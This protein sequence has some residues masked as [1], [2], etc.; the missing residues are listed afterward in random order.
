[1]AYTMDQLKAYYKNANGGT[2]PTAGQT[3]QLQIIYNQNLSG[4]YNDDQAFQAVVDLASDSTT[5]VS[6]GTYEFF[7]GFAPSKA[8]LAAL[9]AAYVGTGT[10]ANMNAENRF[11]A[12]SISLALQNPT[13][14]ANF[15]SVYG[16]GTVQEAA[17][18]AYLTII[19]NVAAQANNIN[20]DNAVAFLTSANSI[21]YYTALV[22]STNPGISAADLE[23]GVRAA[24]VGEI[25]FQATSYN[26]G[27][28]IGSYAGASNNL[29][30][31]LAFDGVLTADNAAGIDLFASYGGTGTP[32]SSLVLTTGSDVIV[33]TGNNDTI[34]ATISPVNGA[35]DSTSTFSALDTV[36]GGAGTDTLVLNDTTGTGD[37]T[38]VK[39]TVSNVETVKLQSTGSS[40]VDT[41][42]WNGVTSLSTSTSGGVT[43]TAGSSTSISAVDDKQAA[44]TITINGG[45]NVSVTTT[46]AGTGNIAIGQTTAATG[47]VTVKATETAATTQGTIQVQGGTTVSITQAATNAVNTTATLGAV[48]VTGT[49]GTTNVSVTQ[50]AAATAAAAV[51]GVVGGAVTINDVNAASTTKAGTIATVTIANS[52]NVAIGDNS[53]TALN[54]SGIVGTVGIT[55]NATAISSGV[56]ATT[57]AL[58]LGKGTTGTITANQYKTI[59]A[60]VTGANTVAGIAASAATAL[61]V[62][63]SDVLTLTSAAGLTA[64]TSVAVTGSA[65]LT[66]NL[67]ALGTV[68]KV[69]TSG[70]TGTSTLTIDATKVAFTGGAGS[71]LITLTGA[72]A[73]G[74]KID[75]GAG[76]DRL[77]GATAVAASTT[78]VIDGGT[79]TDAVASTLINAG[80]GALFK[81]FE[82][83]GLANT[84]GTLDASL[85]TG[86]TLTGLELLATGGTY[87]GVLASQSLSV[88]TNVGAGTTTLTFANVGGSADAYTINFAGI[89]GATAGAAVTYDAGT[90]AIA[91]I[92]NVTINSGSASGFSANNIDLTDAAARSL[93]ITGSQ[94]LDVSFVTAFGTAGANGLATIDASAATGAI[95][96][97]T[98]NAGIATGGLTV[99]TGSANDS[100][101][102]A[103]AA[104]ISTGAGNDTIVAGGVSTINAGVG[105]DTVTLAGATG[106]TVDLGAGNDTVTTSAGGSTITLGGGNDAINV[107]A[108]VA[109]STTAPTL[110]TITDAFGSGDSL[111]FANQGTEVFTSAAANVSAATSLV[112]AL[113]IAI[114]AAGDTNGQ[115]VWFQ[116]GGNTYVVEH[117]GASTNF[118]VTDIVVKLAGSVDLST[119][120]YTAGTNTLAL[121]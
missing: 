11:I 100:V 7:L 55:A 32:G 76:N 17:K 43:A 110:T 114:T 5:A 34:T 119:A 19:G 85:L 8:G 18:L 105:N 112:N 88:A 104:T 63:G 67:S 68:S 10:Q 93:T 115:I 102:L 59:N 92:E 107:A 69:D 62:S 31:D 53:L 12:Q 20:V 6:V 46:S 24:V 49:A 42:S 50:T 61:N 89:G 118:D 56:A 41:S 65:G 57:L 111:V 54:L 44:G 87:T 40:T 121:A 22:K 30:K 74:G 91:N 94:A 25:L 117:L 75:L 58:G 37:F 81:N 36:D 90:V 70:T 72:L 21:T 97:N 64:L 71:D 1:M 106:S 52:G 99:S 120:S 35:G 116:Y 95:T 15:A 28:G 79:G 108:T 9:N 33:G 51:Q 66:A 48:T 86:S 23:L 3:A 38:T 4:Q 98:T 78:T 27:A 80:N 2:D 60:A 96:L 14:K 84:S 13:A 101:T 83:L 77:A 16:T 103:S 26:N 109:A 82:V 47:T 73:S 113:D 39:F 45:S 29:L